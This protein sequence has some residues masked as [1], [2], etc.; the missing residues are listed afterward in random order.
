MWPVS[1]PPPAKP[2][3]TAIP[4]PS[5]SGNLGA[6]LEA[7]EDLDGAEKAYLQALSRDPNNWDIAERL[8]LLLSRMGKNQEASHWLRRVVE[9]NPNNVAALMYLAQ[10]LTSTQKFDEAHPLLERAIS[11]DPNLPAAYGLMGTVAL[12]F[13]KFDDANMYFD[14]A[15]EMNPEQAAPYFERLN[16]NK[17]T[18]E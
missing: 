11:I 10:S 13:G 3:S 2:L 6:A 18:A 1:V 15:I 12:R 17:V 14:K 16:A 4:N 8:G 9:A 5:Y 7:N